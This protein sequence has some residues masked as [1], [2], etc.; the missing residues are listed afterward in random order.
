MAACSSMEGLEEMLCGRLVH[1]LCGRSLLKMIQLT[2]QSN[3]FNYMNQPEVQSL[4]KKFYKPPESNMSG[5]YPEGLVF[6]LRKILA[7][8]VGYLFFKK[9][10]WPVNH[11]HRYV[12]QNWFFRD[13][14]CPTTLTTNKYGI[15]IIVKHNLETCKRQSFFSEKHKGKAKWW[16]K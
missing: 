5:F 11:K 15:K 2:P 12:G 9:N 13:L 14:M 6:L 3:N 16:D 8:I 10:Q 7:N 1:M 4:R